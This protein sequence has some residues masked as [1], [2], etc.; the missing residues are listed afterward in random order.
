MKRHFILPIISCLLLILAILCLSDYMYE[1]HK[2]HFLSGV[3]LVMTVVDL[4]MIS[5]LVRLVSMIDIKSKNKGH[6]HII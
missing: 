6:Y 1:F 4:I 2:N 3:S 5:A